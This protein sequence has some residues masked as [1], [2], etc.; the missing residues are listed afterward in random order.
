MKYDYLA[1]EERLQMVRARIQGLERDHFA[2]QIELDTAGG[3]AKAAEASTGLASP[4]V[5]ALRRRNEAAD[6]LETLRT[7]EAALEAEAE[8]R[9]KA[10][11]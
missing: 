2:A 7:E 4:V 10:R 1:P 9:K 5:H 8:A 6:A 11:A 3:E